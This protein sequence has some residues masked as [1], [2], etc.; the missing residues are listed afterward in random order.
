MNRSQEIIQIF[1]QFNLP[2][3]ITKYILHV[4]RYIL[5]KK[6]LYQWIKMSEI[7]HNIQK[8]KFFY[9]EI[10][11][12]FL[13]EIYEINGNMIYLKKYKCM[14]YKIKQENKISILYVNSLRF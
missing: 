1:S 7:F 3:D 13:N 12:S 8:Q 5:Y 6:T 4:E 2:Q 10:K 14:L 9:E 11:K